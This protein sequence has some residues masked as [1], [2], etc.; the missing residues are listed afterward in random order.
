M[1]TIEAMFRDD[2]NLASMF[3]DEAKSNIKLPQ[4]S[5][6]NRSAQ[7]SLLTQSGENVVPT[8]QN[9]MAEGSS[10]SSGLY[11]TLQ[12][13]SQ[14]QE[15][16]ANKQALIG[17]LSNP[18]IDISVKENAIREFNNPSSFNKDTHVTTM[19]NALIKDSDTD[20]NEPEV[21]RRSMASY[22]KEKYDAN[23][24]DQ[25]NANLFAAKLSNNND[26]R[27]FLEALETTIVPFANNKVVGQIITDLKKTS[28]PTI[29]DFIKA[30]TL[31]GK[32]ITELRDQ[33]QSLPASESVVLKNAIRKSIEANSS[34]IFSKD[35]DYAKFNMEQSI[36]DPEGYGP[37]MAS[38]DNI[39]PLLDLV[40]LSG[41]VRSIART[42]SKLAKPYVSTAK[43]AEIAAA[44]ARAAEAAKNALKTS[45]NSSESIF[46][47][48]TVS[49]PPVDIAKRAKA[50]EG[51]ETAKA[52][53][54]GDSSQ[55][56]EPGQ[57]RSIKEELANLPTVDTSAGAVK[58]RAKEI[59]SQGY[60]YKEALAEATK[61]VEAQAADV[62][63]TRSR[64]EGQL[65]G[66]ANASK[67]EQRLAKI[68]QKITELKKGMPEAPGSVQTTL[69][70]A[71]SRIEWNGTVAIHNPSAVGNLMGSMNPGLARDL[72]NGVHAAPDD[73]LA[74]AMF[75]TSKTETLASQLVPQATTP[76]GPVGTRVTDIGRKVRAGVN[77]PDHLL[78]TVETAEW[79]GITRGEKAQIRSN[80]VN[81]IKDADGLVANDA[82]GGF[83]VNPSGNRYTISGVFGT[84][85]GGFLKAED[86]LNQAKISL[87][88]F[89]ISDKDITILKREGNDHV[90]VKEFNGEDGEFY[91]RIDSE[92]AYDPTDITSMESMSV[93]RNFFDRFAGIPLIRDLNLARFLVDP[94]SMLDP[95]LT[96]AA[97]AA[98][99]RTSVLEKKLLDMA[100]EYAVAWKNLDKQGKA[101]VELAITEANEKG[102]DMTPSYLIANFNP[103][104]RLALTKWREFWD[105]HYY[106][107]NLDLVRTLNNQKYMLIE[108]S[109]VRLF[110]KE[111]PKNKNLSTVYDPTLDKV[112]TLSKNEMDQLYANGGTIAQL[113]R[114]E[115][116]GGTV[117]E[118]IM[119]S[120]NATEYLRKITDND[121]I[122][123][124][125]P[126]YYQISYKAPKFVD[127]LVTK[128][129]G[130]TY[131]KAVAVAGDSLTAEHFIQR[132]KT[133][134]PQGTY[135][136]PR[137]DKNLL[138]SDNDRWDLNAARGRIAQRHRGKLLED[139]DGLN[140]LG[141]HSFVADPVESAIRAS[142]SISGRT[143]SRPMLENAKM[144]F[145]QVY[146]DLIK[147]EQGVKRYPGRMS[148]IA[149][150]G[151]PTSKRMADARTT[152]EYI[153]YLENGY[154]NSVDL[155]VKGMFNVMGE[156]LG[157][158]SLA[159][160]KNVPFLAKPL[161]KIERASSIVANGSGVTS[162]AKNT[163]FLA[164]LVAHPLRQLVV[165]PQQALRLWAYDA[166]GSALAIK[167]A[168][169]IIGIKAGLL[170][171]TKEMDDLVKFVEESGQLASVDRSNLV[172][173]TLTDA[174][175]MSGTA[176][177]VTRR[178]TNFPRQIGF[179]VGEQVN[180][181]A[182]LIAAYN[183]YKRLGMDLKDP[184]VRL[185]AQTEARAI[186]G[187]MNFAG[188][189]P[190]NQ[191]SLSAA[192]QFAQVP[193]K[194][195]LQLTNR[196][197]DPAIR[198]RMFV[199]DTII[200]GPP[201]AVVG[202]LYA[203][204]V[205]PES[206]DSFLRETI[207]D[208]LESAAFNTLAREI[209]GPDQKK[210]DFN[211][212]DPYDIDGW[213]RFFDSLMNDGLTKTLM[214]SPSGQIFL[215]DGGKIQNIIAQLGRVFQPIDANS[216]TADEVLLLAEEGARF[217]AGIDAAFKAKIMLETGRRVDQMGVTTQEKATKLDAIAQLFGFTNYD[218]NYLMKIA[219]ET[220]KDEKKKKEDATKV[221]NEI[222]HYYT[223]K[224]NEGNADIEWMTGVSGWILHG[225]YKDDPNIQMFLTQK[226]K[227]DLLGKDSSFFR[228]ILRASGHP[229]IEDIKRRV[230]Q[231]P[232]K[233]RKMIMEMF[234]D[235][236][237]Y[238]EN[239][240]KVNNE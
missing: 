82:M 153:N 114:P 89:G 54:L 128:P 116:F 176:G 179:D 33:I 120:N 191:G 186:S 68:E 146:G 139:T 12:R 28:N 65:A 143:M 29:F 196:K 36:N 239:T 221:Y 85:E 130:T 207:I 62:A 41:S 74:K 140:T 195:W 35:S 31:A 183:K 175:N 218:A 60:S 56:L 91:V 160:D 15:G 126:G 167:Q 115:D 70:E 55:L 42:A 53:I 155:T 150:V 110:A 27:T 197:I 7:I 21:V 80:V 172:R 177:S 205:L 6:R 117:A 39:L 142:R 238:R 98:S 104:E 162:I 57:V 43:A 101:R 169:D 88:R 233:D 51:L 3:N 138:M 95:I 206:D 181:S 223:M 132:M 84:S 30:Y 141:D 187:E 164:Y 40:G 118:H 125:R 145:M 71:M 46:T 133:I 154:I 67:N 224:F 26:D 227:Q 94:A 185:M 24:F 159:A 211:S 73:Q 230:A 64:L 47:P 81:Q 151:E 38:I 198:A 90:P 8:F 77:V 137:S 86:A 190:Y 2:L 109:N 208:G 157:K 66:N 237:N 136:P 158:L 147:E 59:Q 184:D 178:V 22:I 19:K 213:K 232:E 76:K 92:H 9:L 113:R 83:S 231:L 102:I 135:L 219:I 127:K 45:Q 23:Q 173:G 5:L 166:K 204:N 226:M 78:D 149:A 87:R 215:K 229:D 168:T 97:S 201:T 50:I 111:V 103:E 225:A 129:D 209:M 96:R 180:L 100:N 199:A 163:A 194:A 107:E 61:Q 210:I 69:A 235:V 75:G 99:D 48:S 108:N 112:V 131:R 52:K 156:M 134:D 200:W 240:K 1:D 171:M 119:V 193:H 44:E 25:V 182:H 170:P 20:K 124:Y 72:H 236:S 14:D 192:L 217:F 105:S 188:D 32:S 49:T 214:N 37:I 123:N 122:L 148:D 17:I 18:Q 228:Q 165:Q 10:G 121:Q 220:S 144:R 216:K 152:W 203:H 34:T 13:Q 106:L 16:K 93:K 79:I 11:Q 58:E 212:L 202:W 63:A 4:G 222:K 234:N 161:S 189:M 174:A